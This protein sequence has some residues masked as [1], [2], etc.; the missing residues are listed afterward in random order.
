MGNKTKISKVE[1]D[2]IWI[3]T[4]RKHSH[5]TCVSRPIWRDDFYGEETLKGGKERVKQEL[6]MCGFDI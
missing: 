1:E 2:I 5:P 6:K 3:S 4:Y